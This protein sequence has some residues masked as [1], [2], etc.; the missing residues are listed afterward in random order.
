LR[1]RRSRTVALLVAVVLLLVAAGAG[2]WWL[3]LRPRGEP[4]PVAAAY[5]DGW[6]RGDWAAMRRLVAAPPA[7]FAAQHQRV[8]AGLQVRST[9]LTPGPV[10]RDGDRAEA[11][12]TARLDLRGLGPWTYQGSLH[13]ARRDRR[14]WKVD[15]SP[16][17]IHPALGPGRRLARSRGWPERAAILAADGSPLAVAADEVVVGLVGRRVKD[18]GQVGRV[19]VG[20]AGA[21]RA[22]VSRLLDQAARTPDQF[23]PVLSL[24]SDRYQRIRTAIHPVP[25]LAFQ[26]RRGRRAVGPA[27]TALL[28]GRVADA[29]A[30]DLKEL[31]P[32]YQPG[33]RVG[34]GGFEEAF[35]RQLAGTP[36]GDV[37]LVTQPA[38]GAAPG[39]DVAAGQVLHRFPAEPGSPVHTTVDPR[40]QRA[41]ERA[42]TGVAKPAALVALKPSTGEV[43]AVVNWPLGGSFNRALLGRYP[44]G[45]TFKVVTTAAL[46]GGG[47]RPD[48]QVSCPRK[49]VVGGR[50]FGNFEGEVLGA[51]TFTRAFA[52]SCNTAFVQLAD[53]RLDGARLA[54]AAGSFGFGVEPSA[55]LPAVTGRVPTPGDDAEL[56]AAV[57][58]QDR[59]VA[60]PLLMAGVAGAVDAGSWHPPRLA[61]EART[62][63]PRPLDPRVAASLRGLMRA[64]VREGTAAPAHL[65]GGTAGKT[66][67]AEFGS[68]NPPPTH[69]WF[70][71]FRGDLA[72]AVVV[73]GGG[74]GGR[75]AAPIAARFLGAL[76]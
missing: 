69:A 63:A 8:L 10:R 57:I 41:A 26:E 74:V 28:V 73:E 61:A 60:S 1:P 12:F 71:G 40:V 53:R 67:T 25:G 6:Q 14:A 16:A 54:A 20:S 35:E 17:A 19:L 51:I 7:D 29:T 32:P 9:V 27:S 13:L 5:L 4:G 48:D 11:A 24:P 46:L 43:R 31:G 72:F 22:L 64:V 3:V 45:S 21:D 42:L 15:W 66:G 76:P 34:H 50:T 39:Q 30:E 33:D 23:L 59:V 56:A 2:T 47:L 49:A 68:G 75:V 55:G 52:D 44:P 37:R 36:G 18:R 58:G 38:G 70:V 62:A 65:P